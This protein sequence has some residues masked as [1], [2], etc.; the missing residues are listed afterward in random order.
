MSILTNRYF[1]DMWSIEKSIKVVCLEEDV[2]E[3]NN[4][5]F[6]NCLF[7]GLEKYKFIFN[8]CTFQGC[9]I[10]S[11]DADFIEC[12]IRDC[13]IAGVDLKLSKCSVEFATFF[14][15]D[16]QWGD[17]IN[18]VCAFNVCTLNRVDVHGSAT[19]TDCADTLDAYGNIL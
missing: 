11:L 2:Y 6:V 15:C 9:Q 5:N 7:T 10:A 4:L 19:F 12:K 14:H 17:N 18:Q 1:F 8:N 3:I 16:I 13:N